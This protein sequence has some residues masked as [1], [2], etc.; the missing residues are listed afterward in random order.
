MSEAA[1][2][3][4]ELRQ[5]VVD[6]ENRGTA[7]A[8]ELGPRV[9]RPPAAA[10][11]AWQERLEALERNQR[12]LSRSLHYLA[13]NPQVSNGERRGR[14]LLVSVV[15]PVR[16]RSGPLRSALE[17]VL[18]QEHLAFEILVIDDGSTDR[19]LEVARSVAASD[20]RIRVFEQPW[21]GSSAAR[22][23]GLLEARG[24]VVVYLDSDVVMMP[25]Y[26][27]GLAEAYAEDPELRWTYAARLIEFLG[28]RFTFIQFEPF[29]RVELERYNYID[30]NVIAHRRG[31]E[32]ELG[33]WD[34]SLVITADWDLAL[35]WSA[36]VEPKPLPLL[37]CRYELG[38]PDQ[39]TLSEPRG[40]DNYRVRSRHARRRDLGIRVLYAVAHYPQLTESYIEQEIRA[41]RANG[42]HVEVWSFEPPE[43][44]F[45]TDVP[46]HSGTLTEAVA[47][48][49]PDLIQVHWLDAYFQR[50]EEL[51][52]IGL[53]IFVRGHGYELSAEK[54]AALESDPA[55][56]TVFLVP[57]FAEL[58]SSA[59]KTVPAW[60]GFRPDLYYPTGEKDRRLVFRAAAGLP[61]KNLDQLLGMALR[62]PEFRFV[63]AVGRAGGHGAW[64][65]GLLERH[66]ASGSPLEIHVNLQHEQV[67][68]LS[69]RAGIFLHTH[70][71]EQPFSSP[72]S[73]IEAMASGAYLLVPRCPPAERYAAEA[74]DYYGDFAEAERLLRAT[75]EWPEAEWRRRRK[76]AIDRS[77]D[78]FVSDVAILPVLKCWLGG[79]RREWP[80]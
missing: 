24:D 64:V 16:N 6:L 31:L 46:L 7:P 9:A 35:R 48:A 80:G 73:I 53:P 14:E 65:D 61:T 40:Y 41:A 18:R 58:W 76:L 34:I 62:N 70:T 68:E 30:T 52:A 2:A 60:V 71:L 38:R 28:E 54:V 5:R 23:R 12:H 1:R 69:R 37:A 21:M 57:H 13:A 20:P 33:G 8:S 10:L 78:H 15:V 3:I 29:D 39:L 59:G 44:P 74:A 45:A 22:A 77:Y 32:Q 67:A 36:R 49:R 25:G 51:R 75:L 4:G 55:V 17:S 11:A 19:T 50:S 63:L 43:S 56:S 72:I 79:L 47:A 27:V 42:V 66:R 26:L